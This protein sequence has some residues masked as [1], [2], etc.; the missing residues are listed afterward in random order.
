M[1]D[2]ARSADAIHQSEGTQEFFSIQIG[3][4]SNNKS[5]DSYQRWS[6]SNFLH[7]LALHDERSV[8]L[9]IGVVAHDNPRK[10]TFLI[11]R[12]K[13]LSKSISLRV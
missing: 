4:I 10:R 9:D 7:V 8:I 6:V 2:D 11:K 1:S 5:L 13:G 12:V 3:I